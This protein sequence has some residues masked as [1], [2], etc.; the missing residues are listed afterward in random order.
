MLITERKFGIFTFVNVYFAEVPGTADIPYCDFVTY[1]TNKD[2]GDIKGFDKL[3]SLTTTIDLSQDINDIWSKI[4]RQHKR[5]IR[6]AEK[7]GTDITVSNNYEKFHRFYKK[8]LNQKK[9]AD[10][11]G[12]NIPSSK[13]MQRY[14]ILFIAEKNGETLGGD[15]YFHDKHNTLLAM[16]AYQNRENT[17]ENKK[18]S[19]D[20]NCY[21]HWEAMQ[22]FK[23]MDIINFDLG[24]VSCDDININ[25]QMNGGE[26]FKR[27][28]GGD[29]ISRFAYT[30][31]NSRFNKLLFQS[32]NFLRSAL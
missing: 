18:R 9:Y 11:S 10:P 6:R 13:F 23:N 15:L 30:K 14:G 7:D 1:H 12:L 4:H 16:H 20:A 28:F 5:H 17:I 32:W 2:W 22:Y 25:H 8:F 21:L 29:A 27:S 19:T 31:F 26:Y 3:K 24:D